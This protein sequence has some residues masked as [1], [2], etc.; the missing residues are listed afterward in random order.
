MNRQSP[1]KYLIQFLRWVC[2]KEVIEEV[3][4]DLVELYI[5]RARHSSSIARL[6]L[7]IDTVKSLRWSNLKKPKLKIYN[8]IMV[9]NYLK[10][11]FRNIIRDIN[12]SIINMLGLSLGLA[13]F[14]LMIIMVNQ[15]YNFDSFHTKADRIFE[16]VQEFDHAGEPE[17]AAHSSILLSDALKAE[18]AMVENAVTAHGAASTWM[19]AK[20]ERFF[21]EDGIV[22]GPEFFEIFDFDLKYGDREQVLLNSHSIIIDEQLAL[23]MFAVE[24]PV[25]EL[26]EIERYGLFTVTGVMEKLP[27]N[28]YMQFNFILSQDYEVFFEH[29]ASWFPRWFQSWRG[30]PATTFVLL[31]DP[32]A[33]P[34]FHQQIEPLLRRNLGEDREI[35]KH[36]LVNLLDL[37]FNSGHIGGNVNRFVKGDT[38]QVKMFVAVAVLVLIMA[39]FNYINI[40][41]ARSVKRTKEVGIR[42]SIGAQRRQISGQ[43]LL[44]SALQ[45][46]FA[47]IISIGWIYFLV[48]Y[49]NTITNFNISISLPIVLEV[50]PIVMLT[51]VLVSII[52][53][54]YPAIYLSKF[55]ADRI[56]KNSM[57]SGKGGSTM[58]NALVLTQYTLVIIIV[59]TLIIVNQ[60]YH[61]LRTKKLGFD[62]EQLLIVEVNGGGVRNNFQTIKS[63]LL[64]NPDISAVA[65]FTTVVSSYRDGTSLLAESFEISDTFFPIEF[66]G[67]DEDG[68][69]TIDLELLPNASNL[70]KGLDSTS[71]YLNETAAALYGGASVVGERITIQEDEDSDFE[72][73][74]QVIGIV[75]D[76]HYSSLHEPI[77]PLVLGYLANP[78]EDIDDIVIRVT[79]PDLMSA[80]SFVEHVHNKF[81]ENDVMTWE[82]LDDMTQRAYNSELIFRDVFVGAS[83][84]SLFIALLGITGLTAYNMITK[85]KEMGIRKVLGARYMQLLKLQGRSFL[86]SLVMATLVASPIIWWLGIYWLENFSYR[87]SLTLLPFTGAFLVVLFGTTITVWLVNHRSVKR[88]PVDALRYQ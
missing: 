48:P 81:D 21:E 55:S 78:F 63:E 29:V 69:K 41:T 85:T 25:G 70:D 62:S 67:M 65:G 86:I 22:A 40:T 84:V 43:F 37:H 35:N 50:L 8:S 44:E 66:Y 82:F 27:A 54:L 24:N 76:F 23:K 20:G 31:R 17:L 75:K 1:P 7:F 36:T 16:V 5:L 80:V 15:E 12:F 30:N 13:V 71:V 79:G 19:T 47:L 68:L 53:G 46:L 11:G 33:A 38:T 45:M 9:S 72:F 87:I 32:E 14:I 52:A 57:A 60:Q 59:A 51:I 42:K 2:R 88:N 83:M 34:Q 58:R 77:G 61:Y 18:I 39:C 10:T 73:K 56:L 74:A 6:R 64:A 28:S 4:G 49:F 3:E 26:I